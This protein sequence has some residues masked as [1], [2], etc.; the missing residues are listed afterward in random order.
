MIARTW[1]YEF[2]LPDIQD[3]IKYIIKKHEAVTTIPLIHVY[4]SRINRLFKGKDGYK[5][6]LQMPETMKSFSSTNKLTDKAKAE[7]IPS[8]DVVLVQ[9]NLVD[10]QYQQKS[11]VLC[12]FAPNKSYAY[13]LNVEPSNLVF[14][15]I[16]NKV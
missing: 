3:Y 16:Y 5:L 12:T 6:E 1:N 11:E 4:I 2:E 8:L 7:N 9:C 13:L 14:L 15:K 10:N